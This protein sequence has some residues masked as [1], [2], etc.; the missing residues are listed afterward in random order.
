MNMKKIAGTFL[1]VGMM[2]MTAACG[3]NAAEEETV[4]TAENTGYADDVATADLVSAAA[5]ALGEN[6]WP[7]MDIDA[8]ALDLL[9]GVKA[10]M[11]EEFSGQAPMI[12]VNVDA[13]VV[14]KVKEGQE[15]AVEEALNAYREY[16]IN[17]ALQYPMNIPKVQ[18]S[19]VKTMGRYVF[20]VQLGAD[21]SAAQEEGDEAVIKLCQEANEAALQA[22]EAVLTK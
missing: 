12:S 13:L 16:N 15:A 1:L 8:E 10:D 19:I 7:N 11:Y 22:M 20:F 21:T 17:D 6:Y 2:A 4:E 3:Q 5:E 18:A 14:I 9:Y